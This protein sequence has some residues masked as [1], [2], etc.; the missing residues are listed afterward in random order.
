M[1]KDRFFHNQPYMVDSLDVA[2]IYS[3]VVE[4]AAP[5]LREMLL[6]CLNGSLSLNDYAVNV[7]EYDDDEDM[8]SADYDDNLDIAERE[9]QLND[10]N[11]QIEAAKLKH[12]QEELAKRLKENTSSEEERMDKPEGDKPDK[13]QLLAISSDIIINGFG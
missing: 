4:D 7:G 2:D 1:V 3:P 13:A 8:T 11:S 9:Q 12:E 10:Y 6:R 5:D